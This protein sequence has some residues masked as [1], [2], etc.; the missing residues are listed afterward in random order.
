MTILIFIP[1]T[2]IAAITERPRRRSGYRKRT[3]REF[4]V[5]R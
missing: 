2:L 1:L 5:G 3:V 4:H